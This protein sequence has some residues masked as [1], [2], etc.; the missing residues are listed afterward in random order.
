MEN[1][2]VCLTWFADGEPASE[3]FWLRND[4]GIVSGGQFNI[5]NEN[6]RSTMTLNSVTSEESGNYSIFVRNV[7]VSV[8]K[9]GE[10]PPRTMQWRCKKGGKEGV[11]VLLH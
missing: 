10:K 4:K 3:M 11:L 1:K 9:H 2:S 8:Y 7:T 5:A 6:K